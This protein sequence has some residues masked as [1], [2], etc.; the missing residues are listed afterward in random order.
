[1]LS[2]SGRTLVNLAERIRGG[3]LAAKIELVIAS[4][5]CLGVE[6][7]RA[8]GLP[9]T[10]LPGDIPAGTLEQLCRDHGVAWVALAGYLRLVNIPRALLGRVVNI[11]PALL[12]SFGG[13][14]LYGHRV[15]EA[16]LAAG[17]KVSGCTV[18]LCD[19]VYDR[20][21]I[22]LQKTCPVLEDDDADSLAARVF[23]LEKA[24]YPEALEL[25]ISGRVNVEGGRARILPAQTAEP[26]RPAARPHSQ[27]AE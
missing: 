20:G 4:R 10:V 16:V 14:G 2:G 9:T 25:L 22:V 7:S 6:R 27:A 24:A 26:R 13:P 17:C 19:E 12:P 21:P 1:M 5:E 18:H 3:G 23:E 11:H 8:L 15:H